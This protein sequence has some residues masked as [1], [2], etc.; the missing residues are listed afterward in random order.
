LK[1]VKQGQKQ[2]LGAAILGLMTPWIAAGGALE[3]GISDRTPVEAGARHSP[4]IVHERHGRNATSYNWSGYAIT[5]ANGSVSHVKGSWKVPAI[6]GACSSQNQYASFWVGIDGYN[7]NTVEQ[8]G[9]DSDCQNGSAVYYAWYEFYPHFSYNIPIAIHVG[10]AIS[11]EVSYSGGKFTLSITDTTANE[12]WS[13]SQKMPNAKR[14]SAE[15]VIEAPSSGGVLP[16][17][18]FGTVD[19]GQDYTGVALS[20]DATVG[21]AS[22]PIGSAAFASSLVEIAMVARDGTT[23]MSQPSGLSADETS[24]TDSWKSAV[25]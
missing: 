25:P 10:D 19:F 7:S 22:G 24:F 2:L 20:C 13:T 1:I 5:G 16:L 18:N 23:V 3:R 6:Q 21:G 17:A 4:M 12:S 8:I 9:T 15:W 11:A 14:S